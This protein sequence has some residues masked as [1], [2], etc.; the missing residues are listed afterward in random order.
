M[1]K[2]R[3][4]QIEKPRSTEQTS[5]PRNSFV[6]KDLLLDLEL[7]Y[8]N[9]GELFKDSNLKDLVPIYDVQSV[10][11][12][13]TNILTTSP[14]QKL[15]NPTFGLDLRSYLF[16]PITDTRAFFIGLDLS[17][18]LPVQEPRITIDRVDVTAI[19][20]DQE[21]DIKLQISIPRLNVTGITLKG[22]LNSSGYYFV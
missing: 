15:L 4:R 5:A 2:I 12:S 21:Y 18:Q 10:L 9:S 6:Y 3:L 8:T 19:I 13:L 14:G 7:G 1:A 11:N 20:D 22:V 16:D 17:Q